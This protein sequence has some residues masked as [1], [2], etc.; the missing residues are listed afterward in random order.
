M[1][2]STKEGNGRSGKENLNPKHFYSISRLSIIN[3]GWGILVNGKPF[4]NIEISGLNHQD[5]GEFLERLTSVV[6]LPVSVTKNS[7]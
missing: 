3:S 4:T 6:I 5:S 2:S 1:S 7:N